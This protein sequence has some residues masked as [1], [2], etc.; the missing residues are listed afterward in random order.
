M[1][2]RTGALYDLEALPVYGP[3]AL[4][5]F[6]PTLVVA[7]HPDDESLACGGL[8]SL[9][10][11]AG[12]SV[13]VTIVSDGSGSHTRSR[14]YPP[15]ALRDLREREAT[16]AVAELGIAATDISFMRFPDTQVPYP[17]CATFQDAVDC[18]LT[19][20]RRR[21][22]ETI[23]VPWRRDPHTDHRAT[24]HIVQAA[25]ARLS[26]CCRVIEYPVWI[27]DLGENG[28]VPEPGEMRGWSLDISSVL[29]CKL[30]AIDAHRSQTTDLIH[31]D[32]AGFRLQPET[33]A[34]FQ[35]PWEVFLEPDHA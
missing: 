14:A 23:L 16:A 4:Q 1:T 29:D 17:D 9:L 33:L 2:N 18:C 11:R 19:V 28:D 8:I 30:A 20:F 10:Q 15:D 5:D 13:C 22:P 12:I 32:P 27:W 35:R 21:V 31:D 24:W 6:G 25:L 26:A 34:H 3:E 7:P